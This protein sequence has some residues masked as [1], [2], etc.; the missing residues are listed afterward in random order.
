MKFAI[1]G[2]AKKFRKAL[3]KN[4]PEDFRFGLFSMYPKNCCEFSSYLL[5]KYLKESCKYKRIEILTGE[6]RYKSTQRHTWLKVE[7]FDVDITAYQF[8]ST[9]RTVITE[10]SSCWHQRYRI[11]TTEIPDLT[12]NQ[13]DDDCKSDLLHDYFHILKKLPK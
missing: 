10:F 1:N 6:N 12:F 11:L 5:A 3:L 4:K 8:S 9:N 2:E 7:G 13:F